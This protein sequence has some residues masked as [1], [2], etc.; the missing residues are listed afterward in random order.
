MFPP[1]NETN[2]IRGDG[3]LF[4]VSLVQCGWKELDLKV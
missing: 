1:K 4:L 3:G 2:T